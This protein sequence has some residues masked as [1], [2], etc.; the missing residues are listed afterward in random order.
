MKHKNILTDNTKSKQTKKQHVS[1]ENTLR[2]F[3]LSIK[4]CTAQSLKK[5]TTTTTTTTT[6]L[7]LSGLCP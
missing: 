2:S 7:C 3:H 5:K 1:K 4:T 6:Q